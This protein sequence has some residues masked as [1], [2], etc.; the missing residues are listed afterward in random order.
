MEDISIKEEK[1]VKEQGVVYV[2]VDKE[3]KQKAE[4]ILEELGL[5]PSAAVQM[6]YKQIVRDEA[7][8]LSLSLR[9]SKR[10]SIYDFDNCSPRVIDTIIDQALL[11]VEK[12]DVYDMKEFDEAMRKFFGGKKWQTTRLLLLNNLR[13]N[14]RKY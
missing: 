2:R 5:T 6:F 3:L 7:L 9:S 14:S 1:P 13:C 8:P 4:S 11:D 12:G 10:S